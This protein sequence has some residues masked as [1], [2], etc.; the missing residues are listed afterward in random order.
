MSS[1]DV[2]WWAICK[3]FREYSGGREDKCFK[4]SNRPT[5]TIVHSCPNI[6]YNMLTSINITFKQY[7]TSFKHI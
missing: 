1:E 3:H 6:A 2:K 4:E 5:P 7:S